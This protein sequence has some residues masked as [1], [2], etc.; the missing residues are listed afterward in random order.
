V[1]LGHVSYPIADSP[2]S[3]SLTATPVRVTLPV[4]TTGNVKTMVSP[5]APVPGV[6]MRALFPTVRRASDDTATVA[7]SEPVAAAPV[8]G[9]PLPSAVFTTAP[10]SMSCWVSGYSAVPVTDC[11]G[12]STPVGPGQ[13]S[14]V[15]GPIPASASVAPTPVRVTLPSFDSTT[16]QVTTV[17]A[18]TGAPTGSEPVLSTVITGAAG[19]V[20][21]TSRGE[22]SDTAEPIGGSPV[23]VAVLVME[24]AST[25]ACVSV[26]V[27]TPVTT[28]AGART[29]GV[30]PL[31]VKA[32]LPRLGR[33]S[34]STTPVSVTL[35]VFTARSVYVSTLP[36]PPVPLV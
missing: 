22:A 33:G 25:S 30:P 2:G 36:T 18:T 24:P 1:P 14:K 20:A 12:A 17:P 13:P 3:G 15:S 21:V 19:A 10:A 31:H 29:P 23:A 34:E 35:P 6:A 27:A 4:L 8:G 7:V 28:S 26:Y 16:D 11:P 9:V 32:R 5:T